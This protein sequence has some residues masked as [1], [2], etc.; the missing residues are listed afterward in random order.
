M[1]SCTSDAAGSSGVYTVRAVAPVEVERDR[2]EQL[3]QLAGRGAAHQVHLEIAFLRMHVAERAQCVGFVGGV[4]GDHAQRVA[5]DSHRR[6][7]PVQ[8]QFAVQRRQAAAQQPPHRQ[9]DRRDEHGYGNQETLEPFAH[10]R[11]F[12]R[13]VDARGRPA[14]ARAGEGSRAHRAAIATD[15]D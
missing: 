1:S 12:R 3:R 9:D 8:R 15:S 2:A 11:G 14:G 5:F 6:R 7:Q 13:A 4:D 10:G